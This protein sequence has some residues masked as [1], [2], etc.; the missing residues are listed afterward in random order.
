[1]LK[2]LAKKSDTELNEMILSG[3]LSVALQAF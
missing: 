3:V 2:T 1:M